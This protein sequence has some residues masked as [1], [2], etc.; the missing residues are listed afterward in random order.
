[1][2]TAIVEIP[3]GSQY[4]YE[5]NGVRLSIDRVL[6]QRV[7]ANY[8]YIEG[9]KLAP[10]G[11]A[12]DVFI[13]SRDPIVPLARM[14]IEIKGIFYCMDKGLEDDKV[15]ATIAG[16]TYLQ[17]NWSFLLA[18]IDQYLSTYKENFIVTGFDELSELPEKYL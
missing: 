9:L 4:K 15:V 5:L 13:L 7:P 3:K 10:D 18:E 1:M 16:D 2:M 14:S 17:A 12:L 8:G 11:D 6:N